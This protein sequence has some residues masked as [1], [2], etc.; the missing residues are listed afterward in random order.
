MREYVSHDTR[1][2]SAALVLALD[3]AAEVGREELTGLV[4]DG[5]LGLDVGMLEIG[6]ASCRER[7]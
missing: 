4:G 1:A 5:V 3:L 2:E 7:V 6:R